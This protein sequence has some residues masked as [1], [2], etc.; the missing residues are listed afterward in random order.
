MDSYFDLSFSYESFATLFPCVKKMRGHLL[1]GD[2]ASPFSGSAR[3]GTPAKGGGKGKNKKGNRPKQQQPQR[4]PSANP[5]P[6]QRTTRWSPQGPVAFSASSDTVNTQPDYP[7]HISEMQ[8]IRA[9]LAA[10][11]ASPMQGLYTGMSVPPALSPHA[12]LLSSAP[13]REFY[14][15]LHGW[16][17]GITPTMEAHAISWGPIRPTLPL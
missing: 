5:P 11:T 2:P 14:C 10:M 3:G 9:M 13:P 4:Q 15:W 12:I 17:N 6:Q 7:A 1:R 16:N 8:E